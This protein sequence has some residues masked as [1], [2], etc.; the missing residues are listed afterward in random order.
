[1][2][3]LQM[4]KFQ[5]QGQS[6]DPHPEQQ[7]WGQRRLLYPLTTFRSSAYRVQPT[8]RNTAA[9]Q[10]ASSRSRPSQARINGMA[11]PMT[12]CGMVSSTLKIGSMTTFVH[13][14][15]P[16]VKMILAELS[17]AQSRF[18]ACITEKIEHSSSSRMRG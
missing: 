4:A 11:R 2:S 16:S 9:A 10:E 13:R 18:P 7:H 6:V 3:E 12:I 14:N 17:A 15:L 8:R 5:A 1:M